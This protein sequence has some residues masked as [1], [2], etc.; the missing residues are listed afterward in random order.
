M[1]K[2][3]QTRSGLPRRLIASA[4]ALVVAFG[5][6]AAQAGP[7]VLPSGGVVAAGSASIIAR[8]PASTLIVQQGQ[9]AVINWQSF[10]IGA[11]ANV[12]FQQ[13]DSASITLNRVTGSGV[14]AINGSLLANGQ[15]WLVNG[16]GILFGQGSRID[17]GGLIATTSDIKD[18]DFL[19]GH[20]AFGTPSGNPDAGVVNQGSIKAATGGSAVLSA[21]HVANEGVI[22]ARLGHVVL[23]GANAFSVAFDGDNLLGYQIDAPVSQT[24]KDADGKP[25]PALVSNS[26]SI[27]AQGG[28]VLMTARAARNVVD[29]VIN[30]TGIIQANAVSL[31]N[32]EVVLDAGDGGAVAVAGTVDVAG[33]NSGESGGTIA[34]LGEKIAVADGAQ[35]NSSGDA[36]G[37]TVLIGGS[38]AQSVMVG[39]SAIA[40]DATGS[41]QGGTVAIVSAGR[42][43]V[44]AALSAKGVTAGGS[45]ETSGH[46][47]DIA[48]ASVDTS[49]SAGA[50]GLWSLDPLNVDIDPT[51]AA[52]IIGSI[53]TTN[54]SVTASNDINVN[55]PL[56]YS[57]S[58][59]LT[60]LAGH[61]LTVNANVQNSGAG[62]IF[63]VAGWDGV[64]AASAILTTAGA[65][66]GNGGS[67]LIGGGSAGAGVAIGSRNGTTTLAARD[68]TV[69][70]VHGF[71]QLGYHGASPNSIDASGGI[72]VL[73]G[74][75]LTVTG[76]DTISGGFAQIG[77]GGHEALGILSGD[78]TVTAQGPVTLTGGAASN[79]NAQIGNGGVASRAINQGNVFL[80][81]GGDIALAAGASVVAGG[82]GDAL[83][84]AA[85]GNFVNQAGSAALTVSGAGRWLVFLNGPAN[86]AAGGLVASPFY[87]RA[88]NFSANSYAA[89]TGAGNRFVYALAPMLTV[90]A[91][92]QTK[93]YGNA[94]PAL[95]ATI[96]GGLPGDAAAGVV[97]GTPSLGTL[98]TASSDVG[99]YSIVGTLG[100]LVSDFNYGFQFVNGT[101]RID[102]ATLT[103]S[104]TGTVRK[105]YDGTSSATL[106]A[107][108]YQL[109]G[110]LFGDSVTLSGPAS[111]A[112]NSKDVGISKL[113]SVSGLAL[114][115]PDRGNYVLASSNLSGAIGVIDPA[116]LTA[117]LTGPVRKIYD[118]TSSATLTAGNYQLIGVLSGDSVTLS[119]PASGAYNS[120]DVG[121]SKLVSASGLALAGPDG[122]NYV[123]ASSNLSG[124]IG[125]ID[126]AAVT[127]LLTGTVQKVF[128]GTTAAALDDSNYALSGV[129]SGDSVALSNSSAGSY[130]T[131]Y[132]GTGKTVSVSGLAL[133]GSDGGNY[134][135]VTSGV[136]GAIGIITPNLAAN[137]L[138]N[139]YTSNGV[140]ISQG[141]APPPAGGSAQ[142]ASDAT[143]DTGGSDGDSVQSDMTAF[144]VGKSLSG[145][146]QSSSSTLI[147]GLLR[148][149]SP[150]PGSALPHGVPPYGQ[151]YSSW[152]NE[153]FWQ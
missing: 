104:L 37:G 83:V 136:S 12:T 25:V 1:K 47:L 144:A 91:A 77:H 55:A 103:A 52:N 120:K 69:A 16:N 8:D 122:G 62:A 58:N 127:V 28:K 111:G 139:S 93:I 130:D 38:G 140:L 72:A 108:N 134:V 27:A 141:F 45:V 17:V 105:I 75:K 59:S 84:L 18:A 118:G 92:N 146:S 6:P 137:V 54:V 123:L 115:G 121:T 24:P 29:N 65:Y 80:A 5:A 61:N 19:S 21:A 35:L 89:V 20:Y 148:Q 86:N 132:V 34:L 41:G 100:T 48:G 124:A 51:L 135:L 150:P 50:A 56:I 129:I 66:G 96:S 107:G 119:G 101:L 110:L 43:S 147:D 142:G 9:N 79:A 70:A 26:G 14:S 102:P 32:G 116:T 151:V 82:S 153:A 76:S 94:N 46:A 30:S 131:K 31:H 3:P 113:V 125:M 7:P 33:R 63:G 68:L 85:A 40:A 106:A 44:A 138:G 126:P 143:S 49:A 10:S 42:T 73:L 152:G 60:F 22:Q 128:D 78:I 98:A 67:I 39:K 145:S 112:Y 90:T 81:S 87:S 71:A 57:S 23:G 74:G 133:S 4:A 99:N 149:F 36:G 53:A 97:S 109:A 13:P 15:V 2:I 114:A 117:S 11:G 88:F 95:T 64:T